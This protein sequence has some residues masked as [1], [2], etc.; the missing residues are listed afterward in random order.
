MDARAELGLHAQLACIWEVSARK[1][2]NVHPGR[3]FA[4]VSFVDF[5]TSAAAL[6]PVLAAAPVNRVGATVLE[7]VRRCRRVVPSNTNLGIILLLAPLAKA[8]GERDLRAGLERVLAGLDVEDAD[9]VYSAIRLANP[10]GLGRAAEQDV[11][12]RPTQT[13]REVMA[14]AAGRDL[15]ARQYA[16][17]FRE[18]FDDGVPALAAGLAATGSLEGAIIRTHLHLLSRHP[19]SL[20]ARKRGLAE[21]EEAGRRAAAVLAADWPRTPAAR[22]ALA[23][24]DAWLRAE[25]HGRN[26]GSTADLIAACLFVCLRQGTIPLPCPWPWAIEPPANGAAFAVT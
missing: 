6:A 25:G 24:L 3:G 22:D 9:L 18:V 21:A 14:L 4:D 10:G 26:P 19:D 8:A 12:E 17:G 23:D 5:L 15:I 1:P 7:A 16:G 2:G 13:L 11:S 20:I